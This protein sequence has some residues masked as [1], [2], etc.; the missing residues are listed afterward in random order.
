VTR[1][2]RNGPCPCGS[3]KKYKS[4]CAAVEQERAERISLFRRYVAVRLD[5]ARVAFGD[6]LDPVKA[7]GAAPSPELA[8]PLMTLLFAYGTANGIAPL[9]ALPA[10][11]DGEVAEEGLSVAAISADTGALVDLM[12]GQTLD[13]P[14][15]ARGVRAGPS[16]A[17]L[18][19]RS[20]AFQARCV[21][22][23]HPKSLPID[24]A[25]ALLRAMSLSGGAGPVNDIRVGHG[26]ICAWHIALFEPDIS[27]EEFASEWCANR[28]RETAD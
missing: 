28:P 15:P 22:V 17:S 5:I 12:T 7:M 11:D 14:D 8:A 21:L 1:I 25:R 27:F 2:S 3:G 10:M 4:C 19:W 9:C 6:K 26:L 24:D 18:V 13:L 23:A 16:R 20:T